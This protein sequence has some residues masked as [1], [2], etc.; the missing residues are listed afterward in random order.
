ML[1][2]DFEF[3]DKLNFNGSIVWNKGKA[4]MDDVNAG[5]YTGANPGA[6]ATD[7][8]FA[9]MNHYVA[10]PAF[11]EYSDLE[12]NQ[13]EYSLGAVYNLTDSISFN[14]NA[15]YLDYSDDEPYLY[16]TDGDVIYVNGGMTMRF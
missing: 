9:G 8:G 1:S 7:P 10:L 15:S 4:E 13:V 16:D 2:A 3:S 11:E 12:I 6:T 14:L 5:T